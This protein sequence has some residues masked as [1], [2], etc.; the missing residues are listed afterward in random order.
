[1]AFFCGSVVA[2]SVA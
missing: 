1:M 2:G